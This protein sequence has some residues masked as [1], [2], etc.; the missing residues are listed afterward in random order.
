MSDEPQPPALRLKP[1]VSTPPETPRTT[2][3]ASSPPEPV[4][5]PGT[6]SPA[7][8]EESPRLRLKPKLAA[9]P[10]GDTTVPPSA[11]ASA[12]P[13]GGVTETAAEPDRPR[14]KPR[15]SS[16]PPPAE[17]SAVSSSPAESSPVLATPTPPE[18]S[19]MPEPLP[20]QAAADAGRF[21][22]KPKASSQGA[23]TPAPDIPSTETPAF[24][25]PAIAAPQLPSAPMPLAPVSETQSHRA[26]PPPASVDV[27]EELAALASRRPEEKPAFRIGLLVTAVL[28]LAVLGGGGYFAYHTF[29]AA[30]AANAPTP[31]KPRPTAASTA[32]TVIRKA[33]N[34]ATELASVP[35][36]LIDKAQDALAARRG[37]EQE[38]VDAALEG[39]ESDGKRALDTRTPDEIAERLGKAEP[40][41]APERAVVHLDLGSSTTPPP[42][43]TAPAMELAA[44]VV[45][46]SPAFKTFVTNA[47]INGV[48]QGDP[49]R[50]LING[51]TVRPGDIL[52]TALGVLFERIDANRKLIFFK[53]QSGAVL[54][55]KY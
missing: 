10:A 53:D 26:P 32:A 13:P 7:E 24:A 16:E 17:V 49:P 4:T 42:A 9:D 35:R 44:P 3:G 1:R 18:S 47:R 20:S 28:V 12:A 51:R 52:D 36:Q 22:L 40:A 8:T 23:P 27:T 46:A 19:P 37:N 41:S 31:L 5:T 54:A 45:T 39:R 33:E 43:S 11:A 29:L 30:P 38:R 14:L 48:F 25:P 21:K 34:R 2:D 55:K 50:A 15:L 6:P